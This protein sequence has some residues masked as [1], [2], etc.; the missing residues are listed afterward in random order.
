VS[1][2]IMTLYSVFVLCVFFTPY[3]WRALYLEGHIYLEVHIYLEAYICLEVATT[4]TP[5][6]LGMSRGD[7]ECYGTR[8]LKES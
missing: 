1:V 5:G 3:V 7:G 8:T 2:C 4:R 6:G